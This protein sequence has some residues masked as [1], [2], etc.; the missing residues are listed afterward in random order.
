MRKIASDY[1]YT[2]CG[3]I[4]PL[5]RPLILVGD[6]GKILSVGQYRDEDLSASDIEYHK[7]TIVP[8]FVNAHCHIE[9]S[10]LKGAFR[11]ATGMSGFINQ[12]NQLRESVGPEGRKKAMA[13]EFANFSKSGVVAVSDISNCN[14][15]FPFKKEYQ[16]LRHTAEDSLFPVYYRTYVELFGTE[17]EDAPS[18]LEGGQKVADQATAMGLDASVTPHSCYTMSPK[19]LEITARRGLE[20]GSISYHSQESQEEEDM[21]MKGSGALADN[22]RGRGLSTP[23]VTGGT[24]L[25]YFIDRIAED[26]RKVK[27]RINL[28]HNVVISQRSIDRAKEALESP[29]FTIC[30]LSNIFIHRA[31][32]PIRLMMENGLKICIGTDSLSS[33]LI[34]DMVREMECIQENFPDLELGQILLWACSNGAQLLGKQDTLGSLEEGKTPGIVLMENLD[35]LRIT[36][37]TKSSRLI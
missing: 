24:A 3:S 36:K 8:G 34:L 2:L 27:G 33:N 32:P 19:L 10:H 35:C 20:S 11:Q 5:E 18:I 1:A 17:K 21:I 12:I 6:D 23:P 29:F 31:L 28:V 13:E 9:L 7:G 14:E 37:E 4:R 26:G 25:E 15:S 16:N 22:Y 30:P